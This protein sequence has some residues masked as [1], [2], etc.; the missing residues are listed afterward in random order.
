MASG[1][2]R[3]AVDRSRIE[4]DDPHEVDYLGYQFPWLSREEILEAIK[5]HGP[6]RDRVLTFLERKGETSVQGG[7]TTDQGRKD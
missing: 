5:R 4:I 6:D 3:A 1:S 2:N 7:S